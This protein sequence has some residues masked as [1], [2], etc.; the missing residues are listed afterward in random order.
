MHRILTAVLVFFGL[1]VSFA[2]HADEGMWQPRQLP[3]LAGEL[4][5]LG[6]VIDPSQLNDLTKHP[7]NAVVS[8]GGCSASFVSP[9]G[10]VVT[11][12]HCAY[13][14]LQYNSTPERNLLESGF[15][16]EN[17]SEELFAGPGSRILVTVDVEDVSATI[18][19]GLSPDLGG[20]ERYKLIEEREKKLIAACEKD[21]GHRCNVRSFHGGLQYFLIKQLEIR[22]VRIVYAPAGAVGRYGGDVDNWIWPRHTGDFA[23]Y[24]AYVGAN[25]KP[26]EYGEDNVPYRPRHHLKVSTAGLSAGDFVMLAGY[27]GVTNRY[28]TAAEVRSAVDWSYPTRKALYE[29]YLEIVERETAN[30][31]DAAIKYAST[32]AGLNNAIK[33]YEGM[34]AGFAR[35]GIMERKRAAEDEL[36]AWIRADPGRRE[37]WLPVLEQLGALVAQREATREQRLYYAMVRRSSM[38]GAARRL[39]RLSRE[40]QKPDAEREPGY[41]ERDIDRIRERLVRI[42]RRFDAAVEQAF[43]DRFIQL[44][45]GAPVDQHVEAL[46]RWFGIEGNAIDEAALDKRL[47]EMYDATRLN[48]KDQRL[49]WMEAKPKQLEK[50][51]DPFMQLAVQLYPDDMALEE[52]DEEISGQFNK[53]RPEFM[54]VLIEW[55]DS[56]GQAVY[57][58]A[59]GT[60]RVSYG[61]VEGYS[62]RDALSYAPF[63]SLRGLVQ[64]ETGEDPFDSPQPLLQAIDERRFGPY[65]DAALDSVPVNFLSNLD[66]T[67]GNSGSPTLNGKGELVGLL[68]DGN[69]ESIISDWVF[70]PEIT[71]SIHVDIR[72]ALW[73]MTYIDRAHHLLVEMGIETDRGEVGRADRRGSAGGAATGGQ[74][75]F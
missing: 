36:R 5:S 17:K 29:E 48:E 47:T 6:L 14:S 31:P 52:K 71:R 39:Y 58:D 15:L 44:Y 42:D 23:F 12:H 24:R 38:L 64:K 7:M 11:N 35:S 54:K 2:S 63:T 28:R 10:L 74:V 66:A 45:A 41:Q 40:K 49:A 62:P 70:T 1:F 72:Y 53:V 51:N 68:F 75:P 59:N 16:A 56:K 9:E 73:V 43:W 3:Q 19:D 21:D 34:L 27:P 46:D 57:A 37:R 69:W 55:L 61:T 50:S 60:L 13:G 32:V 30:R 26:A 8:L 33:N 20:G 18:Q 22:D 4:K 67:G 25:G 65:Y